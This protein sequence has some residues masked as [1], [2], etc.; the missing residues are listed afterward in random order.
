MSEKPIPVRFNEQELKSLESAREILGITKNIWGEKSET[1]KKSIQFVIEFHK[2]IYVKFQHE[3]PPLIRE[4][5]KNELIRG[6]L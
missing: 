1:I 6:N 3:T 2:Y 4:Y 5:I